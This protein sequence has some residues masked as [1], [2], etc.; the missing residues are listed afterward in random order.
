MG[1]AISDGFFETESGSSGSVPGFYPAANY[2]ATFNGATDD[3]AAIN[4]AISVANAAG[5]GIVTGQG[6]SSTALV[7][8]I[9]LLPGVVLYNMSLKLAVNANSSLVQTSAGNHVGTGIS[10]CLLD[11]NGANQSSPAASGV[12]QF[13][14]WLSADQVFVENS[15]VINASYHGIFFGGEVT[16]YTNGSKSCRFNTVELHASVTNGY[17]IYGDF[18]PNFEIIGNTVNWNG[19][20][21]IEMGHAGTTFVNSCTLN[22]TTSVTVASGG[23]P[24]VA[25]GPGSIVSGANIAAGTYVAGI[26]SNTLTLSQAATGSGT[27]TLGFSLPGN[28]RAIANQCTG[29]DIN[30]PYSNDAVISGNYIDVTGQTLGCIGNDTFPANGVVIIGNRCFGA[31]VSNA[32]FAAVWITGDSGVIANNYIQTGNTTTYGVQGTT[33]VLTNGVVN[34]NEITTLPGITSTAAAVGTGGSASSLTIHG[35]TFSGSF[36]EGILVSCNQ[37]DA[38]DNVINLNSG[39]T[40]ALR[41]ASSLSPNQ[42]VFHDNLIVTPGN[43]SSVISFNTVTNVIARNNRGYNPVGLVSI[44]VPSSGSAAAA[45][46]YDRWFYVTAGSS[47]C[48]CAVVN[49][50]GTGQ[51]VTTI[52]ASQY[53]PVYVPAGSTLT[54]T[55]SNAPTW[56]VQGL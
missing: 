41:T 22:A 56:T 11:G 42:I 9:T 43:Y 12:I 54:P 21:A 34:G 31:S 4:S 48:A 40:N 26:T 51:T 18:C 3:T 50:A 2:G 35:N 25:V 49:A 55:Y 33:Q 15:R 47:T 38:S 46:T 10:Y 29:G 6:W 45:A 27:E 7:S 28:M 37:I 52:P 39:A 5:G 53:A 16:A 20:D 1:N 8:Q 17:G 44:S 23:F 24:G 36:A 30:F 32:T 13:N 14:T 19:H